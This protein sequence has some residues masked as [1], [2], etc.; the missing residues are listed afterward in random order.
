M[1]DLT[2]EK[3]GLVRK[4]ILGMVLLLCL[5]GLAACGPAKEIPNDTAA[6]VTAAP[7][8]TPTPMP[9]PSPTP[10]PWEG[11]SFAPD[12]TVM[13]HHSITHTAEV[14]EKEGLLPYVLYTPSTAATMEKV[15]VIVWLH[16]GGDNSTDLAKVETRGLP[17]AIANWELD[18]FNAYV[19][20]PQHMG[21]LI[22]YYWA[23]EHTRNL[24]IDAVI[25]AG[26]GRNFDPDKI[27][28]AGHSIGGMGAVHYGG[29]FPEFWSAAVPISAV[30]AHPY[31]NGF[32]DL[33]VRAYL[34]DHDG[35][36]TMNDYF[37]NYLKYAAD[38]AVYIKSSHAMSG[39]VAFQL[40]ENGDGKSDLIEWMLSQNRLDRIEPDA[41][42]KVS[43]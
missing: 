4:S 15:P 30:E 13:S 10:D 8:P 3:K 40:D 42:V 37:H 41:F 1:A 18:G 2:T 19:V 26:N 31:E 43:E 11:A 36:G 33:P 5:L 6:E 39:A 12:G 34:A 29:T 38:E 7:T 32:G 9:T 23:T 16:G 14:V 21:P 28:I 20:A 27:I 35:G 25:D 24:V 22:K 17:Y